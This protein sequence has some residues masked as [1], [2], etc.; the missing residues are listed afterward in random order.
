MMII[1]WLKFRHQ[2]MEQEECKT[3]KESLKDLCIKYFLI[4]MHVWPFIS[5]LECK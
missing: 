3:L 5:E 2:K 4:S 1:L